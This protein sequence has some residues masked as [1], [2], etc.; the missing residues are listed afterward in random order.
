MVVWGAA[1]AGEVEGRNVVLGSS[2]PGWRSG[3]STW[4]CD[5]A[6][7]PSGLISRRASERASERLLS[8]CYL[9]RTPHP[10]F[11]PYKGRVPRCPRE[12]T[13]PE[14]ELPQTTWPASSRATVHTR[15]SQARACVLC[16]T[17][18]ETAFWTSPSRVQAFSVVEGTLRFSGLG[19]PTIWCPVLQVMAVF[20][21]GIKWAGLRAQPS[22]ILRTENASHPQLPGG[23]SGFRGCGP[24]LPADAARYTHAHL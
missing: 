17:Q 21:F 23:P 12:E 24:G 2:G 18:L 14:V 10:L 11:Q 4:S 6:P 8:P 15:V 13:S 9:L 22:Q 7:H 3:S 20:F 16:P 1:L 5:P 19:C